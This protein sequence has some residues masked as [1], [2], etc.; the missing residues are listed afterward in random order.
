M[1]LI[2]SQSTEWYD[3]SHKLHLQLWFILWV[4]TSN[5]VR[6]TPTSR[7]STPLF[8]LLT[9]KIWI[10]RQSPAT[11]NIKFPR[12]VLSWASE[13]MHTHMQMLHFSLVYPSGQITLAVFKIPQDP[14]KGVCCN[15]LGA[16][17]HV[18]AKMSVLHKNSIHARGHF[19]LQ[20]FYYLTPGVSVTELFCVLVPMFPL[21]FS[22]HFDRPQLSQN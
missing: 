2:V 19:P 7:A 12:T 5:E 8:L 14:C 22:V 18:M 17:W 9:H 1:G 4:I 20:E 21:Y 11:E 13:H 6:M 3:G 15:Y 10:T 16:L